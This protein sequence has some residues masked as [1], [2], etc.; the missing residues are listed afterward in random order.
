MGTH[1]GSAGGGA[2]SF[3][4]QPQQRLIRNGTQLEALWQQRSGGGHR[5][6]ASGTLRQLQERVA[7]QWAPHV[8]ISRGSVRVDQ[9]LRFRR[10]LH[11]V[12]RG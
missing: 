11:E 9:Q 3:E 2:S 7:A 4:R 8:L 10:Q 6:H 5:G 12:W 1:R